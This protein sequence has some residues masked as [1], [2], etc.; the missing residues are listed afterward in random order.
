MVVESKT[1]Y[2]EDGSYIVISY[3]MIEGYD[4]HTFIIHMAG[5]QKSLY[6]LWKEH[7]D[8][9][10]GRVLFC[11]D[12]GNKFKK[13]SVEIEEDLFEYIGDF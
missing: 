3:D 6:R 7:R 4:E 2:T 5:A 12:F 13:H 11:A 1:L 8:L 9:I 10:R